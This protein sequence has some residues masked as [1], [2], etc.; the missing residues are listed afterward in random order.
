MFEQIKK[1]DK[2]LLLFINS[3]HNS[4]FD[5]VMWFASG[6]MSWFPLYVFIIIILIVKSLALRYKSNSV[7]WLSS[8]SLKYRN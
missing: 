2:N 6:K 3:N 4:F 1:L 5:S 8:C 7:N